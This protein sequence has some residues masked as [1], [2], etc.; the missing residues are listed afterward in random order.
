MKEDLW[1]RYRGYFSPYLW[2][3]IERMRSARVA[4]AAARAQE[5][6]PARQPGRRR[7]AAG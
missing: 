6:R 1:E 2:A 4:A 5:I 7:R 3:R